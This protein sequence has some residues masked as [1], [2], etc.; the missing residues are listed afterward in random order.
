MRFSRDRSAI[1]SGLLLILGLTLLTADGRLSAQ[2]ETVFAPFISRLRVSIR[3]PQVRI[4]WEDSPE[5]EGSYQ[6]YR[7]ARTITNDSFDRATLVG[8]VTAGVEAYL[9]VPPSPGDYYY[10]VLAVAENGEPYEIL[11]PGR[12]STFRPV[13]VANLATPAEEAARITEIA[14]SVTEF[15]GQPAIAIAA[16]S[17]RDGREL[18][19]YRSTAPIL[20]D[21]QL[22]LAVEVTRIGSDAI[23][24]VDLPV[25]GVSYYYAILDEE[26]VR[27]GMVTLQAGRNATAEPVEIPILIAESPGPAEEPVIAIPPAESPESSAEEVSAEETDQ[28][29]DSVEAEQQIA[30]APQPEIEPVDVVFSAEQSDVRAIPLPFLQLQ[31]VLSTGR[32]LGSPGI[33]IPDASTL[34]PSTSAAVDGLLANL[35]PTERTAPSR[36][37]LPADRAPS[38]EGAEFTLRTILDG[39]ISQLAWEDALL[40]LNNFFTLPLSPD[41]AARAHFYRGQAYFFTGERQ[42]AILEFLLARDRHYVEV[43]RWLDHILNSP[44]A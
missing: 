22:A 28:S 11:I 1:T 35:T 10:A 38:P 3:D 21:A 24:L 13:T 8:D 16:R 14:A 19:V 40:Q 42:L 15:D 27:E 23:T 5:L 30:S 17:D 7:S 37:I 4:T 29:P 18:I 25:P 34:R 44:G 9:D 6:I 32:R 36:E 2:E 12:N 31:S 41:L 39:P 43:E 33:L 20:E 26:L